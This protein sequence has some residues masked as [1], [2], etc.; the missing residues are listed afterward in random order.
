MQTG[1]TVAV[2]NGAN[3][4]RNNPGPSNGTEVGEDA[5]ELVMEG[6]YCTS[7]AIPYTKAAL[8]NQQAVIRREPATT[9]TNSLSGNGNRHG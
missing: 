1:I 6:S 3:D 4:P 9:R 2:L 8:T 7:D 5:E